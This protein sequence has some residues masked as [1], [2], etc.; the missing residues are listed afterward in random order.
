MPFG[1]V[2]R[3]FKEGVREAFWNWLLGQPLWA[4]LFAAV[5]GFLTSLGAAYQGYSWP[6]MVAVGVMTA[7]GLLFIAERV[8]GTA[9]RVRA[10]W[11]QRR[12]GLH[13]N[14]A[15]DGPLFGPP[16]QD[17]SEPFLRWWHIE[18]SAK[19]ARLP[20]C[21]I[22]LLWN[23]QVIPLL[24]PTVAGRIARL[25]LRPNDPAQHVPIVLRSQVSLGP[26]AMPHGL[27]GG[28]ARISNPAFF[29][30]DTQNYVDLPVGLHLFR[31]R[32]STGENTWESPP[33][34]FA[35]P[36]ARINDHFEVHRL[37]EGAHAFEPPGVIQH[38]GFG[39]RWLSIYGVVSS[40]ADGKELLGL[41]LAR[42]QELRGGAAPSDGEV[43]RWREE[44]ETLIGALYGETERRMFREGAGTTVIFSGGSNAHKVLEVFLKRL[45]SVIERAATLPLQPGVNA[46]LI[47]QRHSPPVETSRAAPWGWLGAATL[48]AFA[49]GIGVFL[50]NNDSQEVPASYLAQLCAAPDLAMSPDELWDEYNARTAFEMGQPWTK[51]DGRCVQWTLGLRSVGQPSRVGIVQISLR[52]GRLGLK[53]VD[54]FGNI[55]GQPV[56]K[57]LRVDD[58]VTVLA[59]ITFVEPARIALHAARLA[60]PP[61]PTDG[62]ASPPS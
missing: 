22:D 17:A 23:E 25:T 39:R 35:I 26:P 47:E 3:F 29:H 50:R 6:L 11:D 53:R 43:S 61:P 7:A 18:V 62:T 9:R 24:W 46:A 1:W 49:V 4:Q 60:F 13:A 45:A 14:R 19:S 34:R 15:E 48:A 8:P 41:A 37:D 58:P 12:S 52:A 10:S 30:G 28:M 57:S 33:Y 38:A 21:T 27:P 40:V 31:L 54:A 32:L 36:L 59:R 55:D 5:S 20:D 16:S 56:L 42:G 44:T 51:Y 2:G